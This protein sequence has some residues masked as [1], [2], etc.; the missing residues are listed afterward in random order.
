MREQSIRSSPR[1]F[2]QRGS[3]VKDIEKSP[4]L[5]MPENPAIM[6]GQ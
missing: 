3:L 6:T 2:S 1:D 4:V 5:S